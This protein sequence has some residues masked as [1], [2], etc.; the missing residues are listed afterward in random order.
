MRLNLVNRTD[1]FLWLSATIT[2]GWTSRDR[3]SH[4][5][6]LSTLSTLNPA[7]DATGISPHAS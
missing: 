4:I 5:R 7:R 3:L 2:L 1:H 6:F